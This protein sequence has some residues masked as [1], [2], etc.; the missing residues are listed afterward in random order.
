[1]LGSDE[2]KILKKGRQYAKNWKSVNSLVSE[3]FTDLSYLGAINTAYQTGESKEKDKLILDCDFSKAY[4]IVLATIP[5][6]DWTKPTKKRFVFK[7]N[8]RIGIWYWKRLL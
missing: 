2:V 3:Y 5:I 1:M 7:R 4:P 8:S 6:I